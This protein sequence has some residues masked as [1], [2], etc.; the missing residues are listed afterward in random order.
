LIAYFLIKIFSF[1][2]FTNKKSL[3][4]RDFFLPIV[5]TQSVSTHF[6]VLRSQITYAKKIIKVCKANFYY[7]KLAKWDW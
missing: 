5:A 4:R 6:L 3:A 1:I 7:R 2:I